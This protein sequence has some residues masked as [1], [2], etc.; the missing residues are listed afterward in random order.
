MDPAS[1]FA[2]V[3]GAGGL[4]LKSATLAK[5]LKDLVSKYQQVRLTILS[6]AQGLDTIQLAWIRIEKWSR[7]KAYNNPTADLADAADDDEF[8][9]RLARS[10][11][12]GTMVMEAFE[13]DLLP[14]KDNAET[15]GFRKRTKVLWNETNFQIHQDRI[16][17]QA[18][19]MSCLLQVVQLELATDHSIFIRRLSPSSGGYAKYGEGPRAPGVHSKTSD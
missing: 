17:S 7:S 8:L 6:M 1:I 2:L 14:Y 11:E 4:A 5:N 12:V 3:E 16:N 18:L 9:Q 10:L 15:F 19:A 13:E